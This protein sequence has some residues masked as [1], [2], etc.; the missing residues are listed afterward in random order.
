MRPVLCQEI[1][2]QTY[3]IPSES[4]ST[5]T[6]PVTCPE[7]WAAMVWVLAALVWVWAA[8]VW[9]WVGGLNVGVGGLGVGWA[10][11]VWGALVWVW[12]LNPIQ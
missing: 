5:E 4:Q 10:A 1:T 9:V 11:L 6:P 3:D 12:A 2:G 7:L 8:S